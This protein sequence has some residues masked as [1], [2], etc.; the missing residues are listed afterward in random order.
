[1]RETEQAIGTL[2]WDGA[3]GDFWVR[4]QQ[5]QDATLSP[6]VPTLLDAAHIGDGES[7]LDLGC[8]CGATTLAA[9]QRVGA[10]GRAVGVDISTAM[11]D[12]ARELAKEGGTEFSGAEFH[13][14]DVQVHEFIPGS[15]D[16]AISRFGV[17]FFD[18]PRAA[19]RNIA[20]ALRPGGRLS[21]VC[22]QP[23][24]ENPHIS[25]PIRAIINAFPDALPQGT[26]QP[27]FSM[28]DPKVIRE[29]LAATGFCDV[30]I[31]S[32]VQDLRVGDNPEQVLEHYLAQPMVRKLLD[33]QPR[34]LVVKVSERI[35]AQLADNQRVDGVYLGSAAWLV[36]AIR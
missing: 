19:F 7:V 9:A 20:H 32:V 17:M 14:A 5:Q 25:L 33:G 26:P 27:P 11:L 36:T 24:K 22:W 15:F 13:R 16:A 12:K 1:M 3:Q 31:V 23:A 28:A 10:T 34:E 29:L 4:E 6:F 30:E 18:D 8:G 2:D 35:T 21:Y